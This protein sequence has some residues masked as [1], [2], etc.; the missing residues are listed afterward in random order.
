MGAPYP[1]K[2]M[3]RLA[4]LV[5][6]LALFLLTAAV[7]PRPAPP[8]LRAGLQAN[9]LPGVEACRLVCADGTCVWICD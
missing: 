2:V 7:P 4:P 6:A 1:F 5:S 9:A 3:P 8:A